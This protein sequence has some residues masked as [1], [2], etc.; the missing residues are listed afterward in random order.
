MSRI[1]FK[2]LTPIAFVTLLGGCGLVQTVTDATTATTQAIFH[3][4]VKTLHLDLSARTAMNID[5]SDMRALSVPT[6]VRIYQLR[7]DKLLRKATYD[8]ILSDSDNVLGADL[9]AEHP[10]VVKPGEGVQLDVPLNKDARFVAV[11]ALFREPDNS[12]DN[13]RLMLTREELEPDRPRVVELGDNRLTLRA[14]A[15]D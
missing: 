3:K 9:L 1:A 10:Q 13:W 6:L 4:Q 15:K 8:Q 2:A 12:A 14:P 7:D 11:V 5:A